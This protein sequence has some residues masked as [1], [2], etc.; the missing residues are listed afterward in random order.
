M[1]RNATIQMRN[2]SLI[3]IIHFQTWIF[4][5]QRVQ[6]PKYKVYSLE[7]FHFQLFFDSK[8]GKSFEYFKSFSNLITFIFEYFGLLLHIYFFKGS[9]VYPIFIRKFFLLISKFRKCL[10]SS[11]TFFKDSVS[12]I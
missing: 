4:A 1:F 11:K 2:I 6:P 3:K 12:H 10:T 5:K 7:S 8:K 9:N